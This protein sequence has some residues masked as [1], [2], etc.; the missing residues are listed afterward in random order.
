[1]GRP[2]KLA[3]H[4]VCGH[5]ATA[6]AAGMDE[7]LAPL[8]PGTPAPDFT[9][10][11]ASFVRVSLADCHGRRVILVFYPGDW[12]PVSREQLRLYQDYLP[13]LARLRAD[14]FGLSTDHLWSHAAFARDAGVRFPLLADCHPSGAV[15]RAYGV[16]QEREERSGRALFVIDER[17]IIRWSRAY[18]LR[19][20]PGVHGILSTLEGLGPA[21][22]TP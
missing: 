16:Y 7:Q 8:P 14:L 19:V 13:V 4:P 15:A 3:F 1:M 17:G 2:E 5:P 11:R 20:N 18:P 10:P 21:D 6:Y 12:E 9:L 22:V